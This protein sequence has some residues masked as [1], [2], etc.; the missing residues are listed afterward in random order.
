MSA[1]APERLDQNFLAEL[2]A[3]RASRPSS[4]CGSWTSL[5]EASVKR[6][7]ACVETGQ[8]RSIARLVRPPVPVE[9][10]DGLPKVA[11]TRGERH[12]GRVTIGWDRVSIWPH[13]P[14]LTHVDAT[15]HFG[16]DGDMYPPGGT[17][18]EREAV[19][20]RWA[21]SGVV[22]RGVF[23]DIPAHRGKDL[24]D[25]REPVTQDELQDME[26]GLP[27]RVERGDALL[28]YTGRDVH[29][30]QAPGTD[31][32]PV[33][34][35]NCTLWIARHEFS[36]ICWDSFDAPNHPEEMGPHFLIWA[37]GQCFVDNCDYSR[38]VEIM[39]A[40]S[41]PA[42]LL[43]MSALPVEGLTGCVVNPLLTL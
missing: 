23:F 21:D 32:G 34:A 33:L 29:E 31:A 41:V 2:Y 27:F 10:S 39:R 35:R 36:V 17:V 4:D 26:D 43:T 7:V 1:P 5:D 20:T 6:G 37:T 18:A 38:A 24:V 14:G 19:W 40:K 28:L 11:V 9:G 8:V 25:R 15:N 42:A 16:L 22:T 30:R 12:E 13:E 3:L